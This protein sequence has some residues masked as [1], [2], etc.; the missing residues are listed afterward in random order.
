VKRLYWNAFV[1][2]GTRIDS[3]WVQVDVGGFEPLLGRS[4][5]E[6]AAVSRS[7]HRSQGFGVAERHGP[8]PNY[9]A[10]R[11]DDATARAPFDGST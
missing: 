7:N 4:W 5:G 6:I 3:T 11:L 2:P 10:P 8:L 9:L 1:R